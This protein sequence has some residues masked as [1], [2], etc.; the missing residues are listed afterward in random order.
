MSEYCDHCG[1]KK[2][3]GYETCGMARCEEMLAEELDAIEARRKKTNGFEDF[4]VETFG[5]YDA[6]AGIPSGLAALYEQRREI[7][8]RLADRARRAYEQLEGQP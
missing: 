5:R 4:L 6:E 1:D 3:V 7:Q 8:S 2:R